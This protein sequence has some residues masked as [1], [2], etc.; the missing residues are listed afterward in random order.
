MVQADISFDY[1]DQSPGFLLWQVTNLWQK[2][3]RKALAE[4]NLTHVQCALLS[5]IG[6]LEDLKETVNQ[7]ALSKHVRADVMMTSQVIRTL[8]T[9]GLV[10]R[11]RGISDPR[12]FSLSLTEKGRG[13]A[14]EALKIVEQVDGR[15]FECINKNKK[16]L[17]DV[18]NSLKV[19]ENGI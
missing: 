15:F 10:Q 12:A 11:E 5:G 6:F 9:K 18:L 19:N 4:L 1:P 8:E 2:I 14:R 13:L 17:V 16:N 3:Q 7:A